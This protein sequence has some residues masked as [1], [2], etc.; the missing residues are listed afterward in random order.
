VV[1]TALAK[2]ANR[3]L[4]AA[5]PRDLWAEL[6]IEDLIS[7]DPQLT[8]LSLSRKARGL[9][10]FHYGPIRLTEDELAAAIARR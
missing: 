2:Q 10:R 5:L 4:Q 6:V 7:T 3:L 8:G 9:A 1:T